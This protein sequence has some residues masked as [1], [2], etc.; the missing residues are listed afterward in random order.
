MNVKR[1][2]EETIMRKIKS[3]DFLKNSDNSYDVLITYTNDDRLTY[4]TLRFDDKQDAWV[5]WYT[6]R[7]GDD[8]VA[9]H[10]SF[11]ETENQVKDEIA[12]WNNSML[13]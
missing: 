3:I 11:Q 12:D 5:L 8:G 7:G 10:E 2:R 9:Y 6:G 4:G 1:N 13:Q